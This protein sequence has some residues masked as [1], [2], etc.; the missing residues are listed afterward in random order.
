MSKENNFHGVTEFKLGAPGD[1]VMGASL[2]DFPDIEN[3]SVKIE[4]ATPSETNIATE[5]DDMYM[6][7]NSSTTAHKITAR[8]FG[9]SRE[10]YPLL[11]GGTTTSG[12]WSAPITPPNIYL[13]FEMKGREV[14][15]KKGIYRIPY[16]KIVAKENGTI[17]K[18]GLP[19]IDIT[20][21]ANTPVSAAG[22]KGAP[23]ESGHEDVV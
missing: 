8:L 12:V 10:D 19:A 4:G 1:G 11:M 5:D 6:T 16:G 7:V 2:K 22:V 21:T 3:N 17:T 13:S 20:I 14:N 9:V 18:S 23:F 15:G